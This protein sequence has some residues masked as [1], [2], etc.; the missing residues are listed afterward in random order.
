MT[1]PV[2]DRGTSGQSGSNHDRPSFVH[3]E[4]DMDQSTMDFILKVIDTAN[5]LAPQFVS[6]LDYSKGFGH[7]ELVRT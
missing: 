6:I 1:A 5:D 3:E 7:T 2:P 4:I